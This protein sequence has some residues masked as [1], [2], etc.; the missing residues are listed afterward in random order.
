MGDAFQR[1][2]FGKDGSFWTWMQIKVVW[3]RDAFL[4]LLNAESGHWAPCI[5]V[6]GTDWQ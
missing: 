6:A 5:S 4:V 2:S 1:W 3:F